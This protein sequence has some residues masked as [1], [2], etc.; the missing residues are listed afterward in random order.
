MDSWTLP[1]VAPASVTANKKLFHNSYLI[2]V[3]LVRLVSDKH[4]QASERLLQIFG[5]YLAALSSPNLFVL[6]IGILAQKT[7]TARP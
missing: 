1:T 2:D 6:F 5:N 4:G 3:D 7:V